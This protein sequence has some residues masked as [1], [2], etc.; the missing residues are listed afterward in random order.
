MKKWDTSRVPCKSISQ[1]FRP[2]VFMTVLMLYVLL[3]KMTFPFVPQS[4]NAC[5]MA[6]ASSEPLKLGLTM[7][8]FLS[9]RFEK[10]GPCGSKVL[11]VTNEMP[12]A[13]KIEV[14]KRI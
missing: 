8:V 12:T 3:R 13:S 9:S 2:V 4:W 1:F 6:G 11:H 10:E 5:M 14:R 7:H